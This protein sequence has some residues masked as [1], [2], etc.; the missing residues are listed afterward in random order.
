MISRIKIVCTRLRVP[1]DRSNQQRQHWRDTYG[2]HEI[3]PAAEFARESTLQHRAKL[4]PLIVPPHR[5]PLPLHWCDRQRVGLLLV[6]RHLLDVLDQSE[7][8]VFVAPKIRRVPARRD[9]LS[10]AVFL[11]DDVTAQIAQRCFEYIKD[12]FRPS[13]ST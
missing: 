9:E 5:Q 11:V 12:E 7:R 8:L 3:R 6:Q 4:R 1:Q 13:S 2:D 10:T